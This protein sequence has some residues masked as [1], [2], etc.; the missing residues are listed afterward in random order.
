MPSSG[1]RVRHAHPAGAAREVHGLAEVRQARRVDL[2]EEALLLALL[3]EH[4]GHQHHVG[5]RSGLVD[6]QLVVPVG[7]RAGF[8][9]DL[10]AG[11][12][13]ERLDHGA[14]EVLRAEAEPRHHQLVRRRAA[15]PGG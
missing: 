5:V 11:L 15:T 13:L 3:G 10:D 2:R 14:L 4:V 12:L 8:E 7:V 9:A 6:Q 1:E